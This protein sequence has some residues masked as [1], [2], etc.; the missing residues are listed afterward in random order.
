MENLPEEIV[1]KSSPIKW[2]GFLLLF[3]LFVFGGVLMLKDGENPLMAWLCIGF[4]GLGIP[5][6]LMQIFKPGTLTL[7]ADGFEQRMMGRVTASRWDEVSGFGIYK[8]RRGFFTTNTF[9][10]FS[11]LEDEGKALAGVARALSGGTAQLGDTFGMKAQKLADL[12]NEFRN[13]ALSP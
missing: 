5:V 11:R 4:F 10:S 2:I 7:N 1:L 9:V 3:I 12:M 6:S 8:I 13:R